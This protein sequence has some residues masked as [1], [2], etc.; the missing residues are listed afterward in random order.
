[1]YSISL[2]VIIHPR[3]RFVSVSSA[4]LDRVARALTAA[5]AAYL[6]A[7]IGMELLPA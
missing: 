3:L 1:M 7:R 2:R 5:S 6:L 4:P